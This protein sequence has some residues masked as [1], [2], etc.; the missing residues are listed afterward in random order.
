VTAVV[1]AVVMMGAGVAVGIAIG[2]GSRRRSPSGTPG[3]PGK[4]GTPGRILFPFVGDALSGDALDCA[5]RLAAAEHATLVPVFIARVPLI[6]PLDAALPGQGARWLRLQEVIE[7]RGAM[8]AV[9]VDPRIQRGRSVRHALRSVIADASWD[10]IV[11]AAAHAGGPGVAA[12][13]VRWLLD[14]AP[15]EIVVLRP[16]TDGAL[17]LPATAL[18]PER[19][20]AS[21]A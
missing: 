1:V 5:L 3:T 18:T 7:Q 13:D 10:R 12:E 6:L 2:A 20:L 4:P 14:Y 19:R 11:I 17:H 16:R 21:V 9:A 8:S 15:D